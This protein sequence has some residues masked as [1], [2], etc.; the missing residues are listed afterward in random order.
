MAKNKPKTAVRDTK[1]LKWELKQKRVIESINAVLSEEG[2][3]LQPFLAYSENG[4]SPQLRLVEQ[5]AKPE[6][7]ATNNDK[8][9][10]KQ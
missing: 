9:E 6:T 5:T 10:P 1:T 7:N 3:M 8:E 2:V 4:I